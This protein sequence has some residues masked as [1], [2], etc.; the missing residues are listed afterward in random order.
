MDDDELEPQQQ[1]EDRQQS[2]IKINEEHEDLI[3]VMVQD[4]E[5]K[6]V[7]ASKPKAKANYNL[8]TQDG[9]EA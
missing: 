1:Q 6:A 5:A 4:V 9:Q 3:A 2:D 8:F 7:E